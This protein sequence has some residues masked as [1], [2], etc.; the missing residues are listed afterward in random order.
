[1]NDKSR[2]AK[3]KTSESVKT[4]FSGIARRY[5]F[6]NS[7]L[8]LRQ[9]ARW[10]KETVRLTTR[11]FP[12][13]D[14][15]LDVCT[16]TAELALAFQ[17]YNRHK[18]KIIGTDFARPMLDLARHKIKNKS[19]PNPGVNG[20]GGITLASADT[21]RLPFR[22][23]SFTICSVAFGLRNLVNFESGIKEMMRVL[24][25]GGRIAIL[26]FA[27][28]DFIGVRPVNKIFSRGY[29]FYFT[30]I[31]PLL[32]N[33]ISGAKQR[34]YSYLPDSVLSFPD[35]GKMVQLLTECGCRQTKVYPMSGGIVNLY[36]GEKGEGTKFPPP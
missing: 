15:V 30:K 32:G 1:M 10:R 6:L 17:K 7:F 26:E 28:P 5:D 2:A 14:T 13:P 36:L 4:M 35:K 31:L 8:S 22:N 34:A 12:D 9:D 3:Q 20:P 24:V 23:N 25:P 11:D 27:R 29:L 19:L 33:L 16:G 18:T 21:L